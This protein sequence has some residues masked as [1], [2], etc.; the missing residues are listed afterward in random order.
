MLAVVHYHSHFNT[1]AMPMEKLH[2]GPAALHTVTSLGKQINTTRE[3]ERERER[4]KRERER[5]RERE[6]RQ[7]VNKTSMPFFI[8]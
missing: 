2:T 5:E 1:A 3:R 4:E 8:I 6:K 7:T